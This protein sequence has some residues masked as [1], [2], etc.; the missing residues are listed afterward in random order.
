MRL[1]PH[2]LVSEPTDLQ[3]DPANRGSPALIVPRLR[4]FLHGL[5]AEHLTGGHEPAYITIALAEL[6]SNKCTLT[7][8]GVGS[9]RVWRQKKQVIK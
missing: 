3:P 8:A 4:L 2:P 1:S 9:G 5:L 7:T 6:R